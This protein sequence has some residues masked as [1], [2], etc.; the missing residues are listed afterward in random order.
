M[1]LIFCKNCQDVRKLLLN[2]IIICSCG[3]CGGKY[4]DIN[5]A[6]YW[7]EYCVLLGFNNHDFAKQI[8]YIPE[9]GLG[10]RF[11]AFFI[12]KNVPSIRKIESD[13]E[14]IKLLKE[15]LDD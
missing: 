5:N 13:E 9:Q 15:E 1:K 3:K 14:I 12:P 10:N 7:G 11:E 8:K 6:I 4:T 2:K